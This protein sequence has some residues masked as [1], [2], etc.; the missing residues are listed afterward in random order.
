MDF[1]FLEDEIRFIAKKSWIHIFQYGHVRLL[2]LWSWLVVTLIILFLF[3][4]AID[5]IYSKLQLIE[6]L[7]VFTT[8]PFHLRVCIIWI[9]QQ[10][11]IFLFQV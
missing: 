8:L 5:K 2:V 10:F 6:F 11:T 3:S 4:I 9:D 1:F 7:S